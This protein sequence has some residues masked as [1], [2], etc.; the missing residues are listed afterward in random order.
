MMLEPMG[1]KIV[2]LLPSTQVRSP[3][4]FIFVMK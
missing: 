1:W 2:R 3:Y 4:S